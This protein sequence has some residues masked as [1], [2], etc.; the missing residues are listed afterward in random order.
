MKFI[1]IRANIK[2]AISAIEKAIGENQNLPIL[3]NIFIEANDNI[4]TFKATNLEIAISHK[5]SG[6]E[7]SKTVRSRRPYH[8]FRA[9]SRISKATA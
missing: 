4:I 7:L 9:L 6:K 3:K 8:S 2:D 1:A 5:V